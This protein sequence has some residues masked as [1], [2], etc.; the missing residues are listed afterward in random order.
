M[1]Q[2]RVNPGH[3]SS[4]LQG[5][6]CK[7]TTIHAYIYIVRQLHFPN[8]LVYG[9]WR[10]PGKSQVHVHV[11][12]HAGHEIEPGI[13]LV[14]ELVLTVRFDLCHDEALL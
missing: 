9:L 13:E 7:P 12:V 11:Q 5:H 4:P 2:D 1:G 14:T 3:F 8:V 10:K 6:I